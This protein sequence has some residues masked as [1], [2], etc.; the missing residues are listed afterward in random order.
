[1]DRVQ[2][3]HGVAHQA[4]SLQHSLTVGIYH[5]ANQAIVMS[6]KSPASSAPA[7]NETQP[8]PANSTGETK[9]KAEPN[10]G[11]Q[12]RTKRNRYISLACNECK[13]RKI[14]CNGQVPCQRCGHLGLECLYAPN[15][16]SSNFKESEE[17][18][19][20]KKHIEQLQ[21]QVNTLFSNITELYRKSESTPIDPSQFSREASRSISGQPPVYDGHNVPPTKP[22]S[23]HP[24]FHGPTST[25]FNFDVAKSSLQ[26][27]GIAPVD[28]GTH[29]L[30]TAQ[31]AT[32]AQTPPQQALA[33]PQLLAHPNKDPL[34]VIKR[35]EAIRLCRNY[36]EE[37]GLMYPIFDIE[38]LI[39]QTN[40]LF[41]F[42]EAADRTGFAKRFKPGADCLS[43]DDTSNL[44]M[45]LAVALIV[46]GN[47][48]S[49]LGAR[50]YNSV[51]H[52]VEAN[53][54]EPG[55]VKTIKL[56]ALVA[57]YHF[58]TDN[59]A[60]AYRLIGIAAR[61]CVE[62]GLHRR[63]AVLKAFNNEEELISVNKL[64]WSI[65]CLDRRWSIGTGLPFTIQDEDIDPYLPEPDDSAPY[66]RSMVAYCR[67]SSKIWYSGVGSEGAAAIKRDKI[68]FLDYQVLQWMKHVPEGLRFYSVEPSPNSEPVSRA[69]QRLRLLLH[70]RGNHLRILI[71]RPVL[72]S[73]TS[74]ME[75]MPYAQT[76]VDI[77]KDTI[78]VL[79]RLNQTTD[80]YR[81]Q[82]ML[83]NYFLVAALAVLFLAVSHAPV[84]FNR[85]VRDEFYMALDLVKG[86]S[87]KS[88]V[89]KRL[90]KTIKGLREIGEK[91]GL[92]PRSIGSEPND[93]HSTAAVAMAGLAGHPMEVLSATYAGVNANNELG[94]S[95]V[96][97][98]QMSN[99]LT[100]LFEAMGAYGGYL[101]AGG[102]EG[103]NGEF[104]HPE[105]E[106][107]HITEGLPAGL[108]N[109]GEFSRIVRDLF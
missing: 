6:A 46:E 70:I 60:L 68:E 86:I 79:T 109:E 23:K 62:I 49:P 18:R 8:P 34:W 9:R 61:M 84:E 48:E 64:F 26:T 69:V 36:E 2:P 59:D 63:D 77:A 32:P 67:L 85:Q 3:Q 20:M 71:Y 28:D 103:L 40:L 27:M 97:G 106:L 108:A 47:G 55:D 31:D 89:S 21:E 43:D 45:V 90:W 7:P 29:E 53:L 35:E 99:E 54:W 37:I 73:A 5:F 19:S 15:C 96:N 95:P 107:H 76:V 87:T 25:A 94:N 75:N 51:K 102:G 81:S 52:N 65:Y 56:L 83:F 11:T 78:R 91:L 105:G 24:R 4:R 44:K 98:L 42:L 30:F 13:R 66:L 12:T 39:T 82:Q 14:K 80:I 93:P 58:H 16:C 22:R 10:S 17:F 57:T 88:Y 41:T 92:F 38:K 104:V 74:I 100:N 101:H 72:H 33:Y 50:F 1:M